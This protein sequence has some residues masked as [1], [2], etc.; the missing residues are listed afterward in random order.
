MD[1]KEAAARLKCS[2]ALLNRWICYGGGPDYVKLN[3]KIVR[4]TAA[5][6]DAFIRAHTIPQPS[7]CESEPK[8]AVST[9]HAAENGR[10]AWA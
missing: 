7:L 4:Y 9:M 2:V 5:S 6:L 1:K 3:G 8:H 10:S